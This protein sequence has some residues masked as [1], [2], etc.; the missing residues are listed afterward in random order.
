M[1]YYLTKSEMGYLPVTVDKSHLITIGERLYSESIELIRELANNAYDKKQWERAMD[2]WKLPLQILAPDKERETEPPASPLSK[3]GKETRNLYPECGET[4]H[5]RDL[6][7]ERYQKSA[8]GLFK[9]EQT[10]QGRLY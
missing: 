5:P 4:H 8:A 2:Q 7:H 3:R 6:P 9:T 1:L 10:P